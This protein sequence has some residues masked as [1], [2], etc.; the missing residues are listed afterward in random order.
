M[1]TSVRCGSS[2]S[3]DRASTAGE[4]GDLRGE[5]QITVCQVA[6][7]MRGQRDMNAVG[8]AEVD[9]GMMIGGIGGCCDLLHQP[10]RSPERA[11]PEVGVDH[12]GDVTPVG[13]VVTS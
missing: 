13:Q 4:L 3:V 10:R 6:G 8:I 5:S 2:G 7:S 11:G 12:C 1:A 9:V